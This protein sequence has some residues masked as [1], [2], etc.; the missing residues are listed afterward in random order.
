MLSFIFVNK[1]KRKIY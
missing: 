1:K